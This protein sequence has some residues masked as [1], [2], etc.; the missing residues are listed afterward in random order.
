MK[1]SVTR[2]QSSNLHKLIRH[3]KLPCI[4]L[5]G[6]NFQTRVENSLRSP[7]GNGT[8]CKF[9]QEHERGADPSDPSHTTA[10]LNSP[11]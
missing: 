6:G 8:S 1:A 11:F 5:G 4:V 9:R 2:L 10:M 3:S 7:G